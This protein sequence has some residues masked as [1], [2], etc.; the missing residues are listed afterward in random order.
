VLCLLDGIGRENSDTVR[1]LRLNK[2][3]SGRY[4]LYHYQYLLLSFAISRASYC[5]CRGILHPLDLL[6]VIQTVFEHLDGFVTKQESFGHSESVDCAD[7]I[8]P[9][10]GIHSTMTREGSKSFKVG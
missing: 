10:W 7:Y 2:E 3:Y 6:L 4:L 9:S 1:L 5:L 8:D